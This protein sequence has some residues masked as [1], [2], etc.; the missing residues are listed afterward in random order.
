VFVIPW[1][2]ITGLTFCSSVRG[3][4]SRGYR[5]KYAVYQDAWHL[6]ER[7]ARGKS[8]VIAHKRLRI[9]AD[10]RKRLRLILTTDGKRPEFT[11]VLPNIA[12]R[13]NLKIV[14][15]ASATTSS[16][17]SSSSSSSR[18]GNVSGHAAVAAKA[19]RAKKPGAQ[20]LRLRAD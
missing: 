18:D 6:V 20:V 5:G 19:Q 10:S 9:S 2:A 3:G 1:D 4:S 13:R 11:A 8:A 14:Q 12:A 16:S 15:P 7:S 17:T